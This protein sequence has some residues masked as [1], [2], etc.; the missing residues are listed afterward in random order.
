MEKHRFLIFEPNKKAG[1][2]SN[3]TIIYSLWFLAIAIFYLSNN[4]AQSNDLVYWGR[5][6]TLIA[7]VSLSG[8]WALVGLWR[9]RPLNGNYN[10]ELEF[11]ED[12]FKINDKQI[13]LNEINKIDVKIQD[14]YGMQTRSR[15]S[16]FSPGLSQ[17]INN[18]LEYIDHDSI[19]NKIFF[20]LSV[21]NQQKELETFIISAIRLNKMTF[22]R[23]IDLL[24]I[25]DYDE[26]QKFKLNFY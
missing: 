8:Y 5:L 9:Y 13:K 16:A 14:Y 3:E 17:G 24:G 15:G 21:K 23:G 12:Y 4:Y 6:I 26:I 1:S 10:G 11:G 25:E 19:N 20:K 18:Y 22:L 7:I 2:V